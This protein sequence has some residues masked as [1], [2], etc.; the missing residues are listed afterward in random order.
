MRRD[1]AGWNVNQVDTMHRLQRAILKSV[2]MW[3]PKE[4]QRCA[5]ASSETSYCVTADL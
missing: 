4:A 2:H 1:H 3:L 5:G